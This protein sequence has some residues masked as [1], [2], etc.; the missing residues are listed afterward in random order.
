MSTDYWV[1][2]AI[3]VVPPLNWTEIR[4]ANLN[5][6][7]LAFPLG[8]DMQVEIEETDEGT[9]T[10]KKVS[11][12]IPWTDDKHAAHSLLDMVQCVVNM[13]PGHHYL[14]HFEVTL[15][16]EASLPYRIYVYDGK[17][18]KVVPEISWPTDLR[19]FS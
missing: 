7:I 15:A 8:V 1:T 9:V 13:C 4:K 19:S 18:V 17:A 5:D 14:G 10:V 11:T 6:S 2:G 16:D 3:E 12:L